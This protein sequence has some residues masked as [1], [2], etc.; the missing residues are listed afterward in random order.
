MH[1][2]LDLVTVDLKDPI[3]KVITVPLI[4]HFIFP[5]QFLFLIMVELYMVHTAWPFG[6]DP[7]YA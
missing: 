5:V 6:L 3:L 2:L 4:D 1:S 7:I